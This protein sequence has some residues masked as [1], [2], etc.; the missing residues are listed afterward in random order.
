MGSYDFVTADKWLALF[1]ATRLRIW[2]F[3]GSFRD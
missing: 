2:L 1:L 3:F